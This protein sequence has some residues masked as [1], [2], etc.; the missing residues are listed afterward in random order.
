MTLNLKNLSNIPST[1]YQIAIH[2][3]KVLQHFTGI[4]STLHYP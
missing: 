4:V 1:V 2:S 3:W